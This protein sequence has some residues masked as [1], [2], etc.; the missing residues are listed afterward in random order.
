[1]NMDRSTVSRSHGSGSATLGSMTAAPGTSSMRTSPAPYVRFA[2]MIQV[3]A[4][5]A[6]S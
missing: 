5:V 1:M 2:R 6:S 3:I 4:T